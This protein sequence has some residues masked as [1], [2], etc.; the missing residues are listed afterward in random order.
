MALGRLA[1]YF[2]FARWVDIRTLGLGRV[3]DLPVADI[4][5]DGAQFWTAEPSRNAGTVSGTGALP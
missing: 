5:P 4:A 1:T 3:A 2:L